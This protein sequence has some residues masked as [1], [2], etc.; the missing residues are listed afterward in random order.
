[1]VPTNFQPKTT[2]SQARQQL[3]E[4]LQQVIDGMLR[5]YDFTQVVQKYKL[6]KEEVIQIQCS[7]N[8]IKTQVNESDTR[9]ADSYKK[10][11]IPSY[12]T[13]HTCLDSNGEEIKCPENH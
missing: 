5:K 8:I 11:D 13:N 6:S 1:M 7:I 4:E 2:N 9:K 10:K 3:L 12:C